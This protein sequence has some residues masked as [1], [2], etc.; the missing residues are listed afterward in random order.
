MAKNRDKDKPSKAIALKYDQKN[1]PAP[2]IAASG[3]GYIAEQ[4]IAIA[5]EHGIPVKKDANLTEI[6][7]V[8][9]VD[10]FI[11]LEAYNAVAEILSY[12]YRVN[13]GQTS[14]AKPTQET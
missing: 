9:E 10:S 11:P 13:A 2:R 5:E 8:L 7:S 6:L 4:I 1:D 3:E 14:A 12:I